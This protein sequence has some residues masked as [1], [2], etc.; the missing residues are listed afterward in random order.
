MTTVDPNS[1]TI[2]FVMLAID[3]GIKE[4]K[5]GPVGILMESEIDKCERN[6]KYKSSFE[7]INSYSSSGQLIII[8]VSRFYQSHLSIAQY[9]FSL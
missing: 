4:N 9:S 1:Y 8:V 5:I 2:S 6:G 7:K 3:A